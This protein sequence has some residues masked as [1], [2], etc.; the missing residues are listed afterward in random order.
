MEMHTPPS[1]YTFGCHI[2]VK[3][4]ILGGKRGYSCAKGQALQRTRLVCSRP[5]HRRENELSTEEAT[6]V[7]RV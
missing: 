6:F 3:N 4:F 5:A 1:S 7:E 2:G